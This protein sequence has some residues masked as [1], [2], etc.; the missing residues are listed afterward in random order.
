TRAGWPLKIAA[1]VDPFDQDYFETEIKPLLD[2]PLVE[3]VGELDDKGKHELLGGA[4]ATLFPIDWPEPFGLTM[5]ESMA[6]GTPVIAMNHGSVPE[7][8]THGVTGFICESVDEMV[9]ALPLVA[10]I[11]RAGCRDAV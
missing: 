10:E 4:Y 2:H 1:K 7:I 6:C 9:A 11:D 3:F 5:I 8:I